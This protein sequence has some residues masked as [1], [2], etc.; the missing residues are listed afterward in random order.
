MLRLWSAGGALFILAAVAVSTDRVSAAT[1]GEG[2]PSERSATGS[3]GTPVITSRLS[4][5]RIAPDGK[6][7]VDAQ[8]K[9]FLPFGVNYFRP[10]TGWAPQVWKQ[11]DAEAVRKDF[12]LLKTYGVNCVRVFLSYGSFYEKPGVLS[13]DGLGKFDQFLKLADEAGIYVHPTGPDHWEGTPEWV[14]QD[15]IASE[16]VLRALEQFWK[17]FASRYRGVNAIFAY[18][19]RNEPSV[20]WNSPAMRKRWTDWVHKHHQSR[21]DAAKAWGVSADSIVWDDVAVPVPED[22]PGDR[23]LLDYQHCREDAAD[24]WTRRQ[25]QAIKSADPSALVT[26]GLIQW[27][28]PAVLPGVQ[29]YSAFRPDRQAPLVDFLE[30]HF[31]PLARGMYEYRSNEERDLNLAYLECVVAETAR[32]GKPVV[33]AEYGWYGGG[34][35]SFNTSKSREASEDDQV[36]WCSSLIETTRGLAVGW[37]NWGVY[38][39]PEA[40]D[41]TQLTGLFTVEGREKAWGRRFREIAEQI[42]KAIPKAKTL[43]R[44]PK[45][46]WDLCITSRKAAEEFLDAYYRAYVRAK[47]SETTG[48]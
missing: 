27:S 10:R 40:R 37:L 16:E 1:A 11:F 24:E 18:D 8:N 9:P 6:G 22:K 39:H 26:V 20:P 5:I 7:F 17:L 3:G 29:H 25:A 23:M 42:T 41:V 36:G 13:P 4:K 21:D 31:Y 38:D 45:L 2:R 43:G 44:R 28:V 12:A 35:L 30:I 48:A 32:P 19:L 15:S 34:A 33:I 47:G 46:D 14:R